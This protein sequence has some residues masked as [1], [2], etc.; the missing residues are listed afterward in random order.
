MI[1]GY[2]RV[3]TLDQSLELQVE[4]LEKFGCELIYK[5]KKSAVKER[6]EFN[7]MNKNARSGDTIVVWKLDRLGRSLRHLI[8]QVN[9]YKEREIELVSI[10][11]KIDTTSATGR[12]MF[13]MIAIFAEFERDLISDRTKA[14]LEAAKKKGRKGGRP[15][16]L[17]KASIKKAWSIK[18]YQD[19]NIYEEGEIMKMTDTPKTTY[20]RLTAYIEEII[21]K[22]TKKGLKN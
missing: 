1:I 13:N 10:Q 18:G 17:T 4:A 19:K 7:R 14:G 20:Y 9:D 15:R 12:L 5:E 22:S 21:K 6:K 3:S 8:N 2:A 16:G 11:D